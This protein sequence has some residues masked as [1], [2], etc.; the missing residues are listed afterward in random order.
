M[1]KPRLPIEGEF[2]RHVGRLI[3]IQ[4]V[5]PK[6]QPPP[7]KDYIFEDIEA[8]CEIRLNGKTIKEIQTY[9]DFY[10]FETGVKSAI[11]EMKEY[12]T[13]EGI[14]PKSDIEVVVIRVERQY[15]A[16][17]KDVTN[18]YDKSF[19]DFEPIKFGSQFDLPH[20]V[21]TIV[22]SSKND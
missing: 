14:G 6:P 2:V 16:R 18:F 9:N 10:G 8:R 17:P 21:E 13:R 5:P 15:R 3:E 12:V 1:N 4:T 22:W 19:F 20:P 11:M 7:T